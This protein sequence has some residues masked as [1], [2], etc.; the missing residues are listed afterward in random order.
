MPPFEWIGP[1]TSVPTPKR[2]VSLATT[3][4]LAKDGMA[5]WTSTYCG[6]DGATLT[7]PFDF[8]V[9]TVEPTGG[10]V[11]VNVKLPMTAPA[12]FWNG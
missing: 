3:A 6:A 2:M 12:A 1:K 4:N 5:I 8:T 11:I 7:T 9:T 10:G